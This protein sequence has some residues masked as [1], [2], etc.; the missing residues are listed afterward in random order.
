VRIALGVTLVSMSCVGA[1]V[2]LAGA[3]T[4]RIEPSK[5]SLVAEIFRDGAASRFAH[6]HVVQATNF[7]GR[8]IFEPAV[9]EASSISVQVNTA[10]LKVDSPET[11]RQFHSRGEPTSADV[12]AIDH[13]MKAEGQLYV[14]KFPLIT[15]L[16]RSIT[17]EKDDQYWVTG[18]LTIR[19]VA[20]LV[21]FPANVII[22]GHIL[23]GTATLEFAQS[24]FGYGPYSAL[25]GAIKNKDA[26]VLHI[27][28]VAIRD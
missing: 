11:R 1:L 28:L 24:A 23:R 25:L 18:H 7:S 5:S 27:D 21:R 19:G 15:F 26:V 2:N 3:A 14:A 20:K 8:I 16:S 13:N 9:P 10:T 12:S 17:S 6:D 4:F 22:E